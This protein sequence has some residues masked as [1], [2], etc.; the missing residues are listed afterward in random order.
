MSAEAMNLS[1]WQKF[2]VIVG[3]SG[4]AL[5]GLQFVV[6]AL[7]ASTRHRADVA[8][9]NAFGTPNVVHFS[10]A[11][12]ISAVM[13]A[14]W[15]SLFAVS[16]ALAVCGVLGLGYSATV[17]HRAR[18]QTAY[19][20]GKR[21]GTGE[22]KRD[23]KRNGTGPIID[24][25]ANW[26]CPVFRFQLCIRHYFLNGAARKSATSWGMSLQAAPSI[27]AVICDIEKSFV[28]SRR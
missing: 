11:L 24:N 5:V 20:P 12:I 21:N 22:K 1:L 15:P 13:N 4:G 10:V 6:I 28:L 2:Y 23:G 27:E 3:S 14:P 25:R 18:R 9:V 7:I 8:S 16:V 19:K 17:F 26:T